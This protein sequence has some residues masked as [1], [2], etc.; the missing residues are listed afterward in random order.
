MSVFLPIIDLLTKYLLIVIPYCEFWEYW[1]CCYLHNAYLF[2]SSDVKYIFRR[3]VTIW[4]AKVL[5]KDAKLLKNGERSM[6]GYDKELL[7]GIAIQEPPCKILLWCTFSDLMTCFHLSA[8]VFDLSNTKSE[9]RFVPLKLMSLFCPAIYTEKRNIHIYLFP[10][11]FFCLPFRHA[12]RLSMIFY[13]KIKLLKWMK[14]R[15]I[16]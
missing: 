16:L 3:N 2:G 11:A 4:P 9:I 1:K 15:F 10:R 12:F 5:N 14:G 7:H 6:K 8:F 13:F